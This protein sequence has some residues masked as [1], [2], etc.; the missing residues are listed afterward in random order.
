[1]LRIAMAIYGSSSLAENVQMKG[2][3]LGYVKE[4]LDES[5]SSGPTAQPN[6]QPPFILDASSNARLFSATCIGV[7]LQGKSVSTSVSGCGCRRMTT[8]RHAA[9]LCGKLNVVGSQSH[10]SMA[11]MCSTLG[12]TSLDGAFQSTPNELLQH[13][14]LLPLLIGELFSAI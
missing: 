7:L 14:Q 5:S 4:A 10:G 9:R 3:R 2:F 8:F 11:R 12:S 1:M 6:A 13:E